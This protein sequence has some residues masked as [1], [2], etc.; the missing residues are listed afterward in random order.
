[1]TQH[2]EDRIED[3]PRPP[4][5]SAQILPFERPQSELQRAVQQRAQ[6]AIDRERERSRTKPAPLRWLVIAVIAAIP[7]GLLFGAIDRLLHVFYKINDTYQSAPPAA[8]P[9][10][11]QPSPSSESGVVILQPLPPEPTEQEQR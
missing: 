5:T 2:S 7:V 8:Q 11:P 9:A 3:A 4:P 6:E 10:P 1:M